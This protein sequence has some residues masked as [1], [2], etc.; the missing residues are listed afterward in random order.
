MA[1]KDYHYLQCLDGMIEEIRKYFLDLPLK[2]KVVLHVFIA[3]RS[4]ECTG[5][6]SNKE[7]REYHNKLF[8]KIRNLLIKNNNSLNVKKLAKTGKN[9]QICTSVADVA[10]FIISEKR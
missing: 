1:N 5:I 10:C 4:S 9:Y 2:E 3:K 7:H 8:E 6:S